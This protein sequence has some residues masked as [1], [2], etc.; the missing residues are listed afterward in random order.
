MHSTCC[1]CMSIFV[2]IIYVLLDVRIIVT[3]LTPA[4]AQSTCHAW[5]GVLHQRSSVDS[6]FL[7][8][9]IWHSCLASPNR[10]FDPYQSGG[11]QVTQCS[12]FSHHRRYV[13]MVPIMKY[14]ESK[15]FN[16]L[17]RT[18]HAR[19]GALTYLRI[20]KYTRRVLILCFVH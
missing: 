15:S 13:Y 11:I 9:E 3:D 18:S 17:M 12:S 5:Q 6:E 4:R 7:N 16:G 8:H 19:Y 10:S 20:S 2:C 14:F 1:E